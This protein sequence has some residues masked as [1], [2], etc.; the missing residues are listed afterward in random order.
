MRYQERY[1][2]NYGL[3]SS[4]MNTWR[5]GAIP[6]SLFDLRIVLLVIDSVLTTAAMLCVRIVFCVKFL[7]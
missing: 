7:H 3:S 1:L 4:A 2:T 6:A 5:P